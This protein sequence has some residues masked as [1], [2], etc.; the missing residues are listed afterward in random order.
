[1]LVA[2]DI[3][4]VDAGVRQHD[5]A[6]MRHHQHALAMAHDLGGFAQ[7]QFDQPRVLVHLGGELVRARRRRHVA[8]IDDAPLGLGYDLLG[9][10]Q[11]I[12]AAQRKAGRGEPVE[13][14][15]GDVVALLVP[16]EFPPALIC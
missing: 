11:D 16:A 5:A 6:A 14:Q 4:G 10:H 1:M 13:D 3:G 7:D 2:C 12:A 9:D 15:V 8:E